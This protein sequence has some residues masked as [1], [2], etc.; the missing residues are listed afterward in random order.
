MADHHHPEELA[1]VG[2]RIAAIEAVL[3]EK[4]I[5]DLAS[6]HRWVGCVSGVEMRKVPSELG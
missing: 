4:G 3:V 5:L 2:A 6:I 1:P